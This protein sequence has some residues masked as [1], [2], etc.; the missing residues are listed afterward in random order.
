M[1]QHR[2]SRN[3]DSAYQK[4]L[5]RVQGPGLRQEINLASEFHSLST[6]IIPHLM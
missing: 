6:K 3:R 1:G 2:W 5:R 4:A